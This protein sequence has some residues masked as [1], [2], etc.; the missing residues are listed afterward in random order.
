MGVVHACR[1]MHG[2]VCTCVLHYSEAC[3]TDHIEGD[4]IS[5]LHTYVNVL[6][7]GAHL[8][9]HYQ[10]NGFENMDNHEALQL[11]TKHFLG[12]YVYV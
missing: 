9:C 12:L 2:L 8:K 4:H 6:L 1:C 3:W 7:T 10:T 5:K 11:A